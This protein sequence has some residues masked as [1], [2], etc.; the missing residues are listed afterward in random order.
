MRLAPKSKEIVGAKDA[1]NRLI[2]NPERRPTAV[3][4]QNLRASALVTPLSSFSILISQ[5]ATLLPSLLSV[6]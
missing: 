4:D 1:F 3:I 6:L 2:G 5:S